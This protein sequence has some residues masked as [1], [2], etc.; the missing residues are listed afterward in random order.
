MQP[1]L[2]P[3]APKFLLPCLC[4]SYPVQFSCSVESDSLPPHGLMHTRPPCHH[5]L[6]EL[7]Q[8]HVHQ[9]CDAIQPSHPLT[10]SSPAFNLS[11]HQ[12]HFKWV[13][14]S[15]Q[16][17]KECSNYHTTA[18]I[19]HVSKVMLKILQVRLQQYMNR[20]LPNVQFGFRK[21]RVTRDQVANI[22]QIIKKAREFQK[23]IYF[24]FIDYAKAFDCVNQQKLWKILPEIRI[25][26]HLTCFLGNMY[27]GQVA[28]VRTEHGTTDWFQI[29]KGEHQGC[30]LS[31]WL[32]NL[33]AETS[34]EMLGWMK[35]KLESRLLGEISITSHIQM[36]PPLQWRSEG[37][38][39][40]TVKKS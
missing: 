36:T 14:S 9:V 20:K 4:V 39:K 11:Q 25:P 40:G 18:L 17:A 3:N 31:P 35:H 29:G 24:C 34:C 16:V 38:A 28:T 15:H 10:S 30:I 37:W 26:D 19:L 27:A 1:V 7:A 12:G 21:G 32:F 5:Q 13:S 2:F 33:Y 6:P 22:C 8:I 23:D